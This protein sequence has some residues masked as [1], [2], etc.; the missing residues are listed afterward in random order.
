[1]AKD[2]SLSLNPTKISGLCGRLMCCLKYE[3][4]TYEELLE[5][6]PQ[7]G[8]IIITPKGRGTIVDTYT[9]LERV[10]AKVRLEDNTDDLKRS[11]VFNLS[12]ILNTSSIASFFCS[13]S[14]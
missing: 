6:M 3:H 2:Q 12:S 1:M 13:L 14:T 5:K 9:L 7:V 11:F 4:E 10:K 8:T